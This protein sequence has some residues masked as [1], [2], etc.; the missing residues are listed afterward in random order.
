MV[1]RAW[2]S[3]FQ[4]KE[5]GLSKDIS[6]ILTGWSYDGGAIS[7]RWIKGENGHPLV[8]LRVDLGLLQMEIKGRPDGGRPRDFASM[9][10]YYLDLEEKQEALGMALI[11][12]EDDC[13]GLQQEALQY[14]YRYLAFYALNYLDGVIED[15]QHNLDIIELVST[16]LEDDDLAWQ[17]IQFFPYVKMMN[18]RARGEILLKQEE[19]DL[20]L[21]MVE[22]AL[23]AIVSFQLEYGD[24]EDT[25]E[26]S[27]E[28]EELKELRMRIRN[29]RP[30]SREESLNEELN[31]AIRGEN[32]ERAAELRDAL[33]A[34]N[35]AK[36]KRVTERRESQ[37]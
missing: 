30:K 19:Y 1:D 20:A 29:K 2:W 15:T 12:S 22:E 13:S 14:Y 10:D 32:Y 34:L 35:Q 24:E 21:A 37:S 28:V 11:L 36:A 9:L 8:Q 16:Y 26:D 23:E 31:R 5:Y 4:R 6:S 3:R 17:F 7:A 18:A 27:Y 33:N 25:E